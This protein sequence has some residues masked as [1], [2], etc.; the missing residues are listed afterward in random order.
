MRQ[1][2]EAGVYCGHVTRKWNPKMSPYIFGVRNGVHI[3]DL[4]QTVPMLETAMKVI[5]DTTANHGR[6]LFVGT[7]AQVADRIKEAAQKCG[8]YYVN[9]RWLGGMLTN[10]KTIS[11]SIKRLKAMEEQIANPVGLTKKEI[12]KLQRERNKL[13]LA[14]GGIREMG[15]LPDLVVIIDTNREAIAVKEAIKLRIPVVAI[16]DSNSNPDGIAYLVPGN[17]D[18]TKAIELYC[19]LF[20]GAVIAGLRSGMEKSGIDIG[21]TDI[22]LSDNSEPTDDKGLGDAA[23]QPASA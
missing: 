8:Q 19:D 11:V 17:D 5:S 15:G 6:I 3:L 21:A 16:V 18:A 1:L 14:L 23:A 13:E 2:L 10:W 20:A 22:A 9:H 4:E 7:K 12:L